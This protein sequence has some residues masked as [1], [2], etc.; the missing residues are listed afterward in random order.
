M[1]K[2]KANQYI[3]KI[4]ADL[5]EGW[6][7]LK[8]I[9]EEERDPSRAKR[10]KKLWKKIK[11][12][13]AESTEEKMLLFFELGKELKDD[14]MR[15]GNKYNRVLARRLYKSFEKSYL[16]IPINKDWKLRH[17]NCISVKDVEDITHSWISMKLNPVEGENMWQI[18]SPLMET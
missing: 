14:H 7:S 2:R 6:Y 3:S 9:L 4:K 8:R 5:Q 16:W 18:Q 17:F 15:K 1:T 10:I 13:K 12:T 11:K